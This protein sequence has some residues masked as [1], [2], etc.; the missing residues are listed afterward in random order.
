MLQFFKASV[1]MLTRLANIQLSL[2]HI[3]HLSDVPILALSGV[4]FCLR[5]APFP[6]DFH[7][8]VSNNAVKVG[9]A[10]YVFPNR[11]LTYILSLLVK[12]H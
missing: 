4:C 7:L 9:Y 3:N 8:A 1:F 2:T 12:A 10:E 11:N 5:H 6:F